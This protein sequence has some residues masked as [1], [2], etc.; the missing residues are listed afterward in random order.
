MFLYQNIALLCP[1]ICYIIYIL[2]EVR[3]GLFLCEVLYKV[4][5]F[6]RAVALFSQTLSLCLSPLSFFLSSLLRSKIRRVGY[7][8][9]LLLPLLQPDQLGKNLSLSLSLSTAARKLQAGFSDRGRT[10]G[11]REDMS[12][13]FCHG[14]PSE[15]RRIFLQSQATSYVRTVQ[16]ST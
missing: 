9:L 6:V 8:P 3:K 14:R 1:I 2:Y 11:G 16:Y 7:S 5:P 15:H 4:V 12:L 13:Q 10:K